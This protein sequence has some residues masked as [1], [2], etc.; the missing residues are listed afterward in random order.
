MKQ[1]L[2]LST[3]RIDSLHKLQYIAIIRL[4]FND[5]TLNQSWKLYECTKTQCTLMI[6]L[7]DSFSGPL[8]DAE[9]DVW[10]LYNFKCLLSCLLLLENVK[11][12]SLMSSCDA[13]VDVKTRRAALSVSKLRSR[14][15]LFSS[16]LQSHCVVF[17]SMRPHSCMVSF[18]RSGSLMH[19]K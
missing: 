16:A 7:R 10:L 17:G 1:L 18:S 14:L 11:I 19:T 9:T 6:A 15:L 3:P 8:A 4:S 13:S 12:S 5:D 2:C